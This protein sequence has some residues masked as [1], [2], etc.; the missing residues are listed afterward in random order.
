MKTLDELQA[1]HGAWSAATFP[2]QTPSSIVAHLRE[3][4]DELAQDFAAD[5]AADCLL[6]LLG[7]AAVRGFSLW[8]AATSKHAVNKA[9][10]W[11]TP[12][13]NGVVHHARE[14]K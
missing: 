10:T 14:A 3:E 5:E 7:L 8:E 11:G 9:R 4:V 13:P 2:H 6:L 1:R 12:D